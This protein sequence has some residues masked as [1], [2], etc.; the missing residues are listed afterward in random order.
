MNQQHEENWRRKF[1]PF[2]NW[3][4]A[5]SSSRS[6]IDD[7]LGE[8]QRLAESL[9]STLEPLADN[10]VDKV[11]A[12]ASTLEDLAGK[13]SHETRGFLAKTLESIAERIKPK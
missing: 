12:L 13:S 9:K 10:A 5:S 4:P 1:E 6:I 7:T 11:K 3:R 8:A 2:T